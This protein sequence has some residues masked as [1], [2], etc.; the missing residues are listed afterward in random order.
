MAVEPN[1]ERPQFFSEGQSFVNKSELVEKQT[2]FCIM[3][4]ED[5]QGTFGMEWQLEIFYEG[6]DE[7]GTMTF[8]HGNPE[9]SKR[10]QQ[11]KELVQHSEYLPVHDCTLKKYKF[12]GVT[13]YRI[14]ARSGGG[15][16][17][18]SPGEHDDEDAFLPP[19]VPLA[20][21]PQE[22]PAVTITHRPSPS[23]PNVVYQHSDG[24]RVLDAA[25]ASPKQYAQI[26]ALA[27]RLNRDV[28]M[29]ETF[30]EAKALI[31]QLTQDYNRMTA[32]LNRR[33]TKT[34]GGVI[35]R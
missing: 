11:F 6:T 26:G 21:A 32:Q 5:A 9:K 30:G 25:S 3:D 12:E 28:S 4:I 14:I 8:A 35:L 7:L 16:C 31:E 10:E 34:E 2:R 17:P 13:G 15:P 20:P 23:E 19:D 29:P 18:C 22:K 27:E 1:Q 33:E 24:S